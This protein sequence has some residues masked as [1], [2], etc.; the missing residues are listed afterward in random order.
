MDLMNSQQSPYAPAKVPFHTHN[1]VDAPPVFQSTFTY[2]GFIGL[3]GTVG[4]LPDGWSVNHDST[5]DYIITHNL[6]TFS[7]SVVASPVGN[8]L[9]LD[10]TTSNNIVEFTWS[11]GSATDT[12]FYFILIALWNK[13][14][15]PATYSP[16]GYIKNGIL[17]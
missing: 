13:N 3:D 11:S 10:V 4:I 9:L 8:S 6:N 17:I 12:A 5:G 2:I 7:Y 14:L 15:P 16:T 1:G